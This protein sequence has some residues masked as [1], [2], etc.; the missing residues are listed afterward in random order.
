MNNENLLLKS[1][2]GCDDHIAPKNGRMWSSAPCNN[3]IDG[4]RYT[5]TVGASIASPHKGVNNG[6][7]NNNSN[8]N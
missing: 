1:D 7:K 4:G 5:K 6:N 2:V 3:K 8:R